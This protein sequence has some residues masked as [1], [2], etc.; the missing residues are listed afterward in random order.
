MD[1]SDIH[2]G[3]D[4]DNQSIEDS[5]SDGNEMQENDESVEGSDYINEKDVK[6]TN[7]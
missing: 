1:E 7:L 5:G 3:E 2:S 6:I 4:E